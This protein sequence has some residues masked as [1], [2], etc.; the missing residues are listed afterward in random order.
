MPLT[1]MVALCTHTHTQIME[2][3]LIVDAVAVCDLS[4]WSSFKKPI[5][6]SY[7]QMLKPQI[8]Y[9]LFTKSFCTGPPYPKFNGML[10]LHCQSK[11][12]EQSK[13]W[14]WT[15]HCTSWVESESV[16]SVDIDIFS[17]TQKYNTQQ[18]SNSNTYTVHLHF[19]H[20]APQGSQAVLCNQ[21]E[22]MRCNAMRFL[23]QIATYLL[24]L[25]NLLRTDGLTALCLH[26][27]YY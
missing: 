4:S 14:N 6:I 7:L 5:S 26:L 8:L 1:R 20:S 22:N 9:L 11:T 15:L 12:Y 27:H 17:Y 24:Q 16:Q 25:M 13:D 2:I 18:H 21:H 3:N 23:L 19:T 10:Q